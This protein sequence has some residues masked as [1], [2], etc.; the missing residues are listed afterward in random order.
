[1]IVAGDTTANPEKKS[2]SKLTL[3][4]DVTKLYLRELGYTPLLTAEEEVELARKVQ[5]GDLKARQK[6]I[7]SNLRLV[8]SIARHYVNSGMELLDLIEE[9]NL[10]L[11]R[12]VEKFNPELGFRFSTYATPWIRQMIERAIMNQSRT[13]RLPIHIFR[14]LQTYR[15][16]TRDLAKDL[17]HPPTIKDLTKMVNKSESEIR[18]VMSLDSNTVS[19]DA[20]IFGE[21]SNA[22]FASIVADE[23]NINPVQQIQA[24]T[25]VYLVDKWLDELDDLPKEVIARRFGLYGYEK[26]T[27]KEISDLMQVNYEK[28]RRVQDSGLR[29]LRAIVNSSGYSREAIE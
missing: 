9:G 2:I 12:A 21:D 13:V 23:N 22:D 28:V 5:Q 26:S 20:P 3:A 29:K 24:D 25:I 8:V 27:L 7:E 15:K 19:I 11:I 16:L 17:D 14:E 10:G 6:M 4:H 18:E 1:M